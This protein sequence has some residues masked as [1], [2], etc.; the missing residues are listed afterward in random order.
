MR[1]LVTGASGFSGKYLVEA[2]HREC[3]EI[4]ACAGPG[5]GADQ[6][7]FPLDLGDPASIRAALDLARPTAIFHLAA[8]TFV[9][10][11]FESPMQTYDVNALGCARLTQA[12]RDYVAAG[13][14]M[15][16]VIF[17]S[18]A[19]VYGMRDPSE[20]PLLE[21][22]DV[23]PATPYA[24]S[25]AAAEAIL[26]S[27]TRAFGLDAIVVRAFNHIGP[28]QNDRFV[29]PGFAAQ[30]ARIAAGGDPLLLVGNLGAARDFLD[31][32][33]VVAA[34][35]ALAR[36]GAPGEVYNACSGAA[37]TIREILRML[38]EIAHVPVEVREDP[39]RMR[40]L[41]VP[42]FVGSHAKLT[43]GTG[44][45]PHLSLDRTLRDVYAA[46]VAAGKTEPR[47]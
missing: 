45:K 17:S 25:K 37:V 41:D 31:V 21:T 35:V 4:L 36:D 9:P 8:Q 14:A 29:V 32:R 42:I 40:P 26:L 28:G 30:L 23:R 13:G 2:L 20:F 12:I 5:D 6:R 38:I 18:S 39:A 15:P 43:A 47:S 44:W 16:R 1:A 19:E 27:E 3:A 10:D 22:L 46:A 33:D 24:G 11:S 34:Y 7:Y